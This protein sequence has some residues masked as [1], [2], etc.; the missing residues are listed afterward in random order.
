MAR[1]DIMRQEAGYFNPIRNIKN[2]CGF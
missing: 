1:G 2:A